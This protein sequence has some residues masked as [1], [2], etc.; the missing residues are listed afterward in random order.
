MNSSL[1]DSC[2]KREFESSDQKDSEEDIRC[3]RLDAIS[4]YGKFYHLLD[5]VKRVET[6]QNTD[7]DIF[8]ILAM[9]GYSFDGK[10]LHKIDDSINKIPLLKKTL[11]PETKT[12][13]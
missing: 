9:I 12:Q 4:D 13:K 8:Q 2:L 7:E 6:A 11:R 10:K 1:I 5:V 3:F